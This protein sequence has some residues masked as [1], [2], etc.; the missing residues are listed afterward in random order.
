M[1]F[2]PLDFGNRDK[3][4]TVAKDFSVLCGKIKFGLKFS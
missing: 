2:L 3:L 4:S 1:L